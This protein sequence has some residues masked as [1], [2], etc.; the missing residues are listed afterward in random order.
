M[1]IIIYSNEE[2][3]EKYLKENCICEKCEINNDACLTENKSSKQ[4]NIN[5]ATI[6]EIKTI[7]GLGESKAKS[8]IQYREENGP[9]KTIE[10]IKNV[11]EIGE[12]LFEKIKDYIT[13]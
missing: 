13:V 8:I 12:A 5:T 4:I 3:K 7:D 11:S 9:F 6:E 2:I 10:E 1:T